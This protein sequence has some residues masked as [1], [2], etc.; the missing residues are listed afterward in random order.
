MTTARLTAKEAKKR[1]SPGKV[2]LRKGWFGSK[3]RNHVA[4][5]IHEETSIPKKP[6]SR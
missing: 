1:L 6:L 5:T 2:T 3:A 4:F